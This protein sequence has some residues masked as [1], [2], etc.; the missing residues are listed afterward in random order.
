M[1]DFQFPDLN[2]FS[3]HVTVHIAPENLEAFYAAMIPVFDVVAAEPECLYFELYQD[4][5]SPGTLSWVE[6]WD[7]TTQWFKDVQMQKAYYKPYF[8]ATMPMYIKDREW[9]ILKRLGPRYIVQKE[10]NLK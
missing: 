5:T 10:A 3:L 1:S 9:R 2:G 7:A 8:E 4:P 6:N